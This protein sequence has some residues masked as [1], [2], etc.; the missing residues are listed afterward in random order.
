MNGPLDFSGKVVVIIGGDDSLGAQVAQGFLTA[1]ASVTIAANREPTAPP[2]GQGRSADFQAC[3]PSDYEQVETTIE[4][5]RNTEGR[6]DTV[7]IADC[8]TGAQGSANTPE[9]VIRQHLVA[10]LNISQL[11]NRIMQAQDDGGNII[12]LVGSSTQP[13]GALAAAYGAAGAGVRNLVTS[14]AVEW[15]PR[16]RVNAVDAASLPTAPADVCNAC[17]FLA[18]GLSDYVSGSCV[19]PGNAG[20]R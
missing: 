3:D 14:L 12:Y 18:S 6:L 11:A 15:A 9:D 5:V 10:P 4:R 19:V 8:H 16:V 20:S 7:V 2:A 17:L 13:D 1:G